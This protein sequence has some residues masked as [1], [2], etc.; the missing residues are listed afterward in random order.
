MSYSEYAHAWAPQPVSSFFLQLRP[1]GG[2][3]AR[4]FKSLAK[5]D[6]TQESELQSSWSQLSLPQ[7]IDNQPVMLRMHDTHKNAFLDGRKPDLTFTTASQ[8]PA[9]F[10]A[11]VLVELT[12][13]DVSPS[14]EGELLSCVHRALEIQV[15][16]HSMLSFLAGRTQVHFFRTHVRER[17]ALTGSIQVQHER[18]GPLELDGDEAS[19]ALGGLLTA[20]LAELGWQPPVIKLPASVDAARPSVSATDLLGS[21]VTSDVY[22]IA[23]SGGEL[24]AKVL[25]GR[26]GRTAARIVEDAQREQRIYA[27]LSAAGVSHVLRALDICACSADDGVAQSAPAAAASRAVSPLPRIPESAGPGGPV[28]LLSPVCGRFRSLRSAETARPFSGRHLGQLVSALEGMHR[29]GFLHRDV[30]PENIGCGEADGELYLLDA[31]FAVELGGTPVLWEGT[32]RYASPRVLA[33]LA[34]AAGSVPPVFCATVADDLHSLVR[35]CY[36]LLHP[37][38]TIELKAWAVQ[39]AAA[40]AK[41]WE[42]RLA[43]GIWRQLAQLCEDQQLPLQADAAACGRRPDAHIYQQLLEQL[44]SLV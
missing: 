28:L 15:F 16:R 29:V 12:V 19:G 43:T 23:S 24:A 3:N 4:L 27:R 25:R 21:G 31:G 22:R 10:S 44:S 9:P 34:G 39:D 8:L 35:C 36:A 32:L 38:L 20:S 26:P 17:D 5:P 37:H 33:A 41:F 42:L 11:V 7:K 30:R 13:D 6:C 40:I 1:P 2:A 18:Y 14:K